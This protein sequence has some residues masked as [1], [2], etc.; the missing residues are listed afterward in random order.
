[1]GLLGRGES[2]AAGVSVP[3]HASREREGEARRSRTESAHAH[4]HG[5][6]GESHC[7]LLFNYATLA[8]GRI[9]TPRRHAILDRPRVGADD[10]RCPHLHDL[11]I[12]HM[13]P[14]PAT[15]RSTCSRLRRRSARTRAPTWCTAATC[16]MRAASTLAIMPACATPTRDP[17]FS[18]CCST[19]RCVGTASALS[20]GVRD[21]AAGCAAA[22]LARV[23]RGW[24]RRQACARCRPSDLR[25]GR[26]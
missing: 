25:P 21:R 24:W 14:R 10:E 9:Y 4:Q 6:V 3:R 8:V 16:G 22:A 5:T 12:I 15:R 17:S 1:M 18:A 13:C 2:E 19:P 23:P 26:C 11:K 20:V 7:S